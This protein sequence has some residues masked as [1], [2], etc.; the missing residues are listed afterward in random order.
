MRLLEKA[1]LWLRQA[2]GR[3]SDV[4]SSG[5]S[6]DETS[7]R[8]RR[9]RRGGECVRKEEHSKIASCRVSRFAAMDSLWGPVVVEEAFPALLFWFWAECQ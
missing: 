8:R 4:L 1:L 6:K 9:W 2:G 3:E 7:G 5:V